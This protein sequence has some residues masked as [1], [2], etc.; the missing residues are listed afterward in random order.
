MAT[1]SPPDICLLLA[2]IASRI[3]SLCGIDVYRCNGLAWAVKERQKATALKYASASQLWGSLGFHSRAKGDLSNRGEAFHW[4]AGCSLGG[5]A[6][7][8][9]VPTGVCDRLDAAVAT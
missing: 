5:L 8:R 9:Q 6:G 1:V 3:H 2:R 7:K 4:M